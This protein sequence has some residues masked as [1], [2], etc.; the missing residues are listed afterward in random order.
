MSREIDKEKLGPLIG[1][2]HFEIPENQR[3][4]EWKSDQAIEL[5]DDLN[6][7]VKRPTEEGLFLGNL[8]TLREGSGKSIGREPI[9]Q[10]VDG[11]QR[12]TSIFILLIAMRVRAQK[13]DDGTS[14]LWM[15]IHGSF[16]SKTRKD[17]Q[18]CRF[19]PSD[20]I[21][22]VFNQAV[23]K[24]WQGYDFEN[25]GIDGRVF[26]G[27][28]RRFSRA[29]DALSDA[30]KTFDLEQI[31]DLFDAIKHCQV[32]HIKLTT[33]EE[34]VDLFE[35]TNA[36]GVQ[37]DAGDLI[38]NYLFTFDR[39]GFD[40]AWNE[41]EENAEQ[42]GTVKCLRYFHISRHGMV[43][44]KKLYAELKEKM[45]DPESFISDLMDFSIFFK[46]MTD[47]QENAFTSWIEEQDLGEVSKKAHKKRALI[48]SLKAL[49]FF[50][51]TQ[52]IPLIYS[53]I[54]VC[55]EKENPEYFK[56]SQNKLVELV[57]RL[58]DFHFHHSLITKQAGNLVEKTYADFAER[59]YKSKDLPDAYSDLLIVLDDKKIKTSLEAFVE[60]FVLITYSASSPD[61]KRKLRYI[62][63]R[64]TNHGVQENHMDL[65]LAGDNPDDEQ[66]NNIE[67]VYAKNIEDDY[68]KLK[69]KPE[70][71]NNIGNLL[72]LSK[73][74]NSSLGNRVPSKKIKKLQ[75]KK[76]R[77]IH[78]A[79][80]LD[81]DFDISRKWD[82]NLIDERARFLA[83]IAYT[84]KALS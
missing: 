44:K 28:K 4:F 73:K 81:G 56:A 42:A 62:F 40:S 71:I 79:Q 21:A 9:Y 60:D 54:K 23:E 45:G 20:S 49:K 18:R 70:T 11:Q 29:Y 76:P 64:L 7:E 24:E 43:T 27:M 25:P 50:K 33:F 1:G 15:E 36:R 41:I 80:F 22:P 67:H 63:D 72:V 3:K 6:E 5:L 74:E 12:L 58:E 46:L 32:V 47:S 77:P 17:D 51:V 66:P 2:A 83:E 26:R 84:T 34:A 69:E 61:V 65:F 39:E 59:I 13:L 55:S 48:R 75:E 14:G 30:I 68:D 57:A 16:M 19:K 31:E 37:L 52:V 38:K 10:V 82:A 53:A 35:R 78:L 8:I